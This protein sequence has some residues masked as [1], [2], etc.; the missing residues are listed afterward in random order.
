M[1]EDLGALTGAIGEAGIDATG[2]VFVCSA[3]EATIIKTKVGAKFDYPVLS[4]PGVAGKESPVSRRRRWHQATRM[5]RRSRPARRPPFTLK[6][7]ALST[8][9]VLMAR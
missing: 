4:T 9:L 3:R 7:A 6:M 1:A 8:L 2:A 5:R